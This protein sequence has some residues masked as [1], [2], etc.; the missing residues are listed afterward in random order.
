MGIMHEDPNYLERQ[1]LQRWLLWRI[2]VFACD[3][4][5]IKSEDFPRLAEHLAGNWL[6]RQVISEET[7]NA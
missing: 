6:Q 1:E 4:R 7:R 3:S 2:N 5:Y